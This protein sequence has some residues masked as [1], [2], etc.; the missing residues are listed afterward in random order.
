MLAPKFCPNLSLAQSNMWVS[1]VRFWALA[2]TL[3]DSQNVEAHLSIGGWTGSRYFSSAVSTAES[4]TAFVKTIVDLVNQ[5]D[6]DGIDFD[7]EYPNKQGIGCNQISSN[8]AS[9]YLAFLQELRKDS[10][11]SKITLSAAVGIAPFVGSNGTP[12]TDVSGFADVLDHIAIMNYDVWGSWSSTVGPNSP[13]DD[14]CAP[15]KAGSA[16]SAVKAWTDAGFPANQIALG[17]AA[18]GHSFHV[19]QQAALGSQAQSANL[20]DAT[21][22]LYPAF[23]KALQ[24][25]GDSQDGAAGQDECG[26][27]VPVGG[28]FNFW[29]LVDGGFLNQDGTADTGN[30]IVYR[31]DNCSQTPFVYSPTSQVMVS[32]DDKTSFAA[33]GKWIEENGL[34]GFAM[35]HVL[36]D[37]DD[38]LLDSISEAMGVEVEQC[39]A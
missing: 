14:A 8:D 5:Y 15:T 31:Y 21:L 32:Y 16:V 11:G 37:F 30:G 33:K 17:V 28:I 27:Q 29:G 23:D 19:S 20:Q 24:P 34:K 3:F 7:W 36:G 26:N 35:W 12:M 6:L 9:N 1:S 2:L 10:T 38:I 18:Y 4:R 25:H 22:Q 13:L 39:G